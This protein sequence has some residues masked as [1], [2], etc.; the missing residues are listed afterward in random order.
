MRQPF[1]PVFCNPATIFCDGVGI[2]GQSQSGHICIESVN[3]G[4][5]LFARAAMALFDSDFLSGF[6]FPVF[7]E[8]SIKFAI[9]LARWV[10]RHIE[11]SKRRLRHGRRAEDKC[12]CRQKHGSK[13]R[14]S[15][16]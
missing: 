1:L 14:P 10:I 2:A 12:G 3:D 5:R 6:G 15:F 11:Q 13:A 16:V 4:A 9:Q 8:G 7:G